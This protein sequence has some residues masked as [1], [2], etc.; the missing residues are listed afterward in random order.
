MPVDKKETH[1]TRFE[2]EEGYKK[3]Q[4]ARKLPLQS[5]FFCLLSDRQDKFHKLQKFWDIS[6]KQIALLWCLTLETK[7]VLIMF[8]TAND[9]PNLAH[10]PFSG[11]QKL[12]K[13]FSRKTIRWR[14]R[15]PTLSK[16]PVGAS[17]KHSSFHMP[18]NNPWVWLVWEEGIMLCISSVLI[19]KYSDILHFPKI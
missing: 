10:R 18:Y 3:L 12:K 16:K 6:P 8:T 9:S 7:T 4:I 17:L 15:A 5:L 13:E 1:E 11:L 19:T 14:A 2:I